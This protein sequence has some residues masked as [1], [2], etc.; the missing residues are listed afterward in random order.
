[1]KNP[2]E[3]TL[4]WEDADQSDYGPCPHCGKHSRCVWGEV[5]RQGAMWAVYYVRWTVE[6]SEH[7]ACFDF[8]IGDWGYDTAASNRFAVSLLYRNDDEAQ[9]F[10]VVD[11]ADRP[12]GESSLAARA[13]RRDEIVGQPLAP[14]IFQIADAIL[15]SDPRVGPIETLPPAS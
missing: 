8:V 7:P 1:M 3:L 5:Y 11:A 6:Q 15:L 2:P 14:G 4:K 9:G 13:L 10:M 12:V